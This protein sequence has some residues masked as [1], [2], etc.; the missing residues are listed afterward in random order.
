[1]FTNL[2]IVKANVKRI[3][4]QRGIVSMILYDREVSLDLLHVMFQNQLWLERKCSTDKMFAESFGRDL[5][6]LS[7]VLKQT[8]LSRG[9]TEGAV[10]S[11]KTKLRDTLTGFAYPRRNL[12]SIEPIV[13]KSFQTKPYKE[14]GVLTKE[15]PPKTFIGKGY[16]DKGTAKEPA[17]D[18][19]P[20]WQDV[21]IHVS[22]VE[23]RIHELREEIERLQDADVL[24]RLDKIRELGLE[25]ERFK[26]TRTPKTNSG[27]A[28]TSQRKKSKS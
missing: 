24:I 26:R 18:G 17:Q 25:A 5:E 3:T 21:A 6:T 13:L 22:H 27:D 7:I 12:P 15:L 9:L 20:R 16:R 28:K 23:R 19:S 11:L 1:M 4:L 10:S 8:N 2:V 14:K